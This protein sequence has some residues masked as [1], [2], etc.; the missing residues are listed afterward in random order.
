MRILA[1]IVESRRIV[2]E[3]VIEDHTGSSRTEKVLKSLEAACFEFDL[4]V[5]MWLDANIREFQRSARVRF[6][7]DSFVE[8]VDFQYLE[9]QVLD[10][11]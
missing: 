9:L 1:K 4:A 2:R 3:T 5:P 11:D 8:P 7:Q 6:T 10:E